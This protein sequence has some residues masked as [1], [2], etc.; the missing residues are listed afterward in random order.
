MTDFFKRTETHFRFTWEALVSNRLAIHLLSSGSAMYDMVL[1]QY[2]HYYQNYDVTLDHFLTG[3]DALGTGRL[4]FQVLDPDE[5]DHFLSTIRRQL[6]EER[7]PF[8]LAFNHTYQFYAE[9]MVMF[10]NTHDQ[11][12]VNVPIL[13]RLTTQKPLNLY[14]IDT[15]P[16]PFDTDTL[17][18][19]NNEYT[20]I[21]NSY[22]Y[23]ALNEH[24]YIPL[25]EPQ[26]R[27]CD[28]MGSTY[29][30]QNSYVLRQR[31]Q[32][33]C[34][35]AIYYK[36]D[37]KMVSKHCQAKFAANVE[38]TPKVLDAGETMVLFNLPRPWILL[39]GQDKR[40]TEIEIATYKVVD[41]KEFCEC[42]LTAGPFQLDETLVKCTLKINSEADGHFKSYFAINKII[43]DYLQA[44]RDVQL[45]STVV[46]ALGRLLDVKPEYNWMPLNWYVNP[47]L[48]D[49]VINQQPSSVIADLMGVMEHIITEGEEEAYQRKIQYRN[50]QSVFKRF[51]KSAEGW[52]KLE[53]V[54]SI[55][56]MIALVALI[57]I[58]IFHS[59][60]VESIIL[61][62]AGMDEYKFVN[63]STS[64]KAF[65]LPPAY[66]HKINFQLPT[67]PPN[68][69]DKG[70]EGKQ[71]IAT[72]LSAWITMFLIIL[73]LLAI[74]YT[75]FKKCRYVS[76]LPRVCF[77][78]YPFS[79]I[80]QGT[81]H[82]DIFVEVVN[83]A[84]AEA[85]WAHFASITIT[86]HRIRTCF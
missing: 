67:L 56:G 45:D 47:D 28:K 19:K 59:R 84:S 37:V 20:F 83:L 64:V 58:S 5:L 30:C 32:H 40:P 17:E 26:L 12:L 2:L 66:P 57:V 15:V 73:A 81:A 68:W 9:L 6:C 23:M 78:L 63:P 79:T 14:S 33:T 75:V 65:T 36:M 77:P 74:L 61:G 41:R 50:A 13:L 55:L 62:S 4:T 51:I 22:P 1:R 7:S 60:I 25:T 69:G 10:T 52:R 24:K 44:E 71:K 42:N 86:D 3:L 72:Q 85:M 8:E 48:S 70:A 18:G 82:T 31:T 43:F 49:N 53:F 46:Q 11:L 38:F 27:M 34:E 29:Y 39:C 35:S 16:M 21:N 76:S 80:L 54:S